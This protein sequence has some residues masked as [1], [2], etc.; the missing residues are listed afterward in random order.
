MGIRK[1]GMTKYELVRLR[2]IA[3]GRR[4]M[5]QAYSIANGNLTSLPDFRATVRE[6]ARAKRAL[7]RTKK[8]PLSLEYFWAFTTI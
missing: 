5:E 3:A 4:M 6:F 7:D 8:T 1:T 2:Y